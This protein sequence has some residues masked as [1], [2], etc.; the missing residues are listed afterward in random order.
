MRNLLL[1]LIT[2][3][4]WPV[5]ADATADFQSANDAYAEGRFD[6]AR[7]TYEKLVEAGDYSANLFYN[8]G[9]AWYRLKD[10]GEAVLNYRRALALEPGHSRA[11][12]NLALVQEA[13][14]ARVPARP[15][16]ARYYPQLGLNAWTWIAVGAAWIF[17]FAVAAHFSRLS[18]SQWRHSAAALGLIALLAC[19][20]ILLEEMKQESAA[21]VIR[22]TTAR[23]APTAAGNNALA[24]P[25]GSIVRWRATR[26]EWAY[27][28]TPDARRLWIPAAD[29]RAVRL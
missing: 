15:G 11:S 24:L 28:E 23:S 1:L 3:W 21:V 7:M 20:P 16:W 6:E 14:G 13:A 17:L 27:A 9:N 25:V 29:I 26:G 12:A 18:R 22:S 19:V 8:L 2:L 10:P 4:A 5:L